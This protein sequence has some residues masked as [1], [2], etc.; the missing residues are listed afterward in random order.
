[1]GERSDSDPSFD[2]AHGAPGR[3]ER[4][5]ADLAARGEVRARSLRTAARERSDRSARD[6]SELIRLIRKEIRRRIGMRSGEARS[7]NE[8]AER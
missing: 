8:S 5:V 3:F 2:A 1:M 7:A 4:I 6:G